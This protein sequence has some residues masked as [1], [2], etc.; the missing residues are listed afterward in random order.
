MLGSN[1]NMIKKN[2][3]VIEP[4]SRIVQRA[5]SYYGDRFSQYLR[6]RRYRSVLTNKFQSGNMSIISLISDSLVKLRKLGVKVTISEE[7]IIFEVANSRIDFNKPDNVFGVYAIL[8]LSHQIRMY[9]YDIVPSLEQHFLKKY[10]T[11]SDNVLETYSGIRFHLESIDPYVLT[12]TFI[13][14]IHYCFPIADKTILDISAAFGDTS[15]HFASEGAKVIAVE[16][17]NFNHL[18]SNIELNPNLSNKIIPLKVAAGKTGILEVPVQ[19]EFDFDGNT[20]I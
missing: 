6:M 9:G 17:V 13:L 7:K 14:K 4:K 5:I 16:P 19:Q 2:T 15:L 11:I 10:F 3:I 1:K 12:E 20:G 18:V 8:E